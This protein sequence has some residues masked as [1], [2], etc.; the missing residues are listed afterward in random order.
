MDLRPKILV[1]VG[2]AVCALLIA[3]AELSLVSAAARDRAGR[4]IALRAAQGPSRRRLVWQ[5]LIQRF[6]SL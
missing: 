2:A 3:A 4:G 6:C 1:I 5:Q